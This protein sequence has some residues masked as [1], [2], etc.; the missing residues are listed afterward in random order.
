MFTKFLSVSAT[1]AI[2]TPLALIVNIMLARWLG[3]EDFGVYSFAIALATFLAIPVAGGFVLLI[4]REVAG[5]FARSELDAL[6]RILTV[7]MGWLVVGSAMVAVAVSVIVF[8]S[9]PSAVWLW[10]VLAIVSGLALVSIGE[11]FLKGLGWPGL[12]ETVRQLTVPVL[13]LAGAAVLSS[14]GLLASGNI[15]WVSAAAYWLVGLIALGFASHISGQPPRFALA[16]RAQLSA[17]SSAFVS[18]ALIGAL[19]TVVTQIG[20]VVLGLVGSAEEVA[21][22][23][24]AERGAQLIALPLSI[25]VAVVSPRIVAAHSAGDADEIRRLSRSASRLTLLMAVP[26]AAILMSAGKPLIALTF[27][28]DYVERSH[29]PLIVLSVGQLAFVALGLPGLILGMCG[30]ER[31]NLAA[32][33]AGAAVLVA[34]LALLVAPFGALGAAFA[35]AGGLTFGKAIANVAMYRKLGFIAGPI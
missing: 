34:L 19:S 11:G 18:F 9:A 4:T 31:A 30:F 32:Q 1:F 35:I 29:I 6:N 8:W 23:R 2:G 10:P 26:M 20:V 24:V 16:S 17:W 7:A 13:L 25:A 21:Y 15:L 27:G 12:A 22:L 28:P 33:I 3:V 5:A 14:Q